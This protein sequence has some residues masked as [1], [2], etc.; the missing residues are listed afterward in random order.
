MEIGGAK[1]VLIP[2]ILQEVGRGGEGVRGMERSGE[3]GW[4]G[5][6]RAYALILLFLFEFGRFVVDYAS[7]SRRERLSC[8]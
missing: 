5:K 3:G 2:N 8:S 4:I 7:V 6:R 1:G